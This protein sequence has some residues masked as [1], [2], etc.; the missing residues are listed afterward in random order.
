MHKKIWWTLI[1]AA[2]GICSGQNSE[3]ENV[4]LDEPQLGQGRNVVKGWTYKSD[5]DKCYMFYHVKRDDYR[6]ENIFL[7]ETACNKKCRPHV[8]VV[9]YAKRPPSKGTSDHPVATYDPNTGRCI[10]IRATKGRGV[11]NVFNNGVSCTKKCR[12][13]DL[14]L[15]LNAT[16]ADCEHMEN[17]ST[18][19][20]YDNVS[21]TCKKSADGSCGGFQSAEKCFQRCAVLVENKCTLPIQN[22]TTCEKPTKRYGYN[23]EKSQCEEFLGCADGGNS[24]EEAK[25]CWSLCAPKHRCNMSPDTGHFPKLG[26]YRRHYFDVTTNDC[27][28]ARKLKPR[29]P[30]NTNLFATPEE[31]EQICKPQYQGTPEH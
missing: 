22:I 31:C 10:N 13:A 6:N 12:D 20:R 14:R 23:K 9:C 17:P 19:Y 27:R 28:S 3:E 30:G 21:Q 7:T 8:P 4:C 1:A 29:V 18:S 15:C 25:E 26:L 11:E 2:F 24:F 16:E 5:L